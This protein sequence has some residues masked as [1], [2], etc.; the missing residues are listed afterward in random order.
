MPVKSLICNRPLRWLLV[1]SCVV[2]CLRVEKDAAVQELQQQLNEL[3]ASHEAAIEARKTAH[4][5]EMEALRKFLSSQIAPDA[6]EMH[7]AAATS[8]VANSIRLDGVISRGA[9]VV[10]VSCGFCQDS[11]SDAP[12]NLKD[13]AALYHH[14][15]KRTAFLQARLNA[16]TQFV[17]YIDNLDPSINAANE[18]LSDDFC[19]NESDVTT[20]NSRAD[21]LSAARTFALGFRQAASDFPLQVEN[22]QMRMGKS[23]SHCMRLSI[24]QADDDDGLILSTELSPQ[25]EQPSSG[26]PEINSTTVAVP[27]DNDPRDSNQSPDAKESKLTD[28]RTVELETKDSEIADLT[29]TV[30]SLKEMLSSQQDELSSMIRSKVEMIRSADEKL[31]SEVAEVTEKFEKRISELELEH[32]RT[33]GEYRQRIVAME[34][35]DVELNTQLIAVT[36]KFNSVTEYTASAERVIEDYQSKAERWAAER[37]DIMKAAETARTELSEREA[38]I[39]ALKEQI[40]MLKSHFEVHETPAANA[41]DVEVQVADAINRDN[42]NPL[43]SKT[44]SADDAHQE[45]GELMKP[46]E[47]ENFNPTRQPNDQPSETAASLKEQ[48]KQVIDQMKLEHR[49]AIQDLEDQHNLK[50]IQLIKDF[51]T[52]MATQEKELQESMNSSLGWS[53]AVLF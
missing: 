43:D 20:V 10:P 42:C 33:V 35:S 22:L 9:D 16:A 21:V 46:P 47:Q 5:E 3:T 25:N 53:H 15:C 4:D 6:L 32:R 12:R 18:H 2:L 51:N 1:K 8:N 28:S 31:R 19:K 27:H 7:T 34:R 36:E 38:E 40:Q 50:V 11:L 14:E 44:S 13:L 48:H 37:E 29:R 24:Q 23:D 17:T 52:Q 26:E 30:D 45:N 41:K 39:V 49:A